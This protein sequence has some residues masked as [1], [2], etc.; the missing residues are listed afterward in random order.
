M[1]LERPPTLRQ[2]R[3]GLEEALEANERLAAEYAYAA[4]KCADAERRIV[5]EVN[6][7]SKAATE[8]ERERSREVSR[9]LREEYEKSS[10]AT[11][12]RVRRLRI[13]LRSA[14]DRKRRLKKERDDARR[15]LGSTEERVGRRYADEVDSLK[16]SLVEGEGKIRRMES[17]VMENDGIVRE[18]RERLMAEIM[19]LTKSFGDLRSELAN[20]AH[21][22]EDCIAT[23]E[24]EAAEKD[25]RIFALEEELTAANARICVLES[26]I[27]ELAS[28]LEDERAISANLTATVTDLRGELDS[29]RV[30]AAGYDDI[31]AILRREV[32]S[33]QITVAE[34]DYK[35]KSYELKE[36][37]LAELLG[38]ASESLARE[39]ERAMVVLEDKDTRIAVLDRELAEKFDEIYTVREA[40]KK[41]NEQLSNMTGMYNTERHRADA[42][43]EKIRKLNQLTA[44]VV[45]AKAIADDDADFLTSGES[46]RLTKFLKDVIAS[47]DQYKSLVDTYESKM[48]FMSQ[49]LILSEQNVSNKQD[50]IKSL[51]RELV[52]ATVKAQDMTAD[53][54]SNSSRAEVDDT[55]YTIWKAQANGMIVQLTNDLKEKEAS[56]MELQKRLEKRLNNEQQ[57]P[58]KELLNTRIESL[59][60]QIARLK[61]VLVET[62]V[63]AKKRIKHKNQSLK[64]MQ[65]AVTTLTAEMEDLRREKNQLTN[66]LSEAIQRREDDY[67]IH[68]RHLRQT[69]DRLS[70]E[71]IVNMKAIE[72][73]MNQT[74]QQLEVEIRFLKDNA[75]PTLADASNDHSKVQEMEESL[76]RSKE[77]EVSL[78][79][80]NMMMKQKLQEML[81]QQARERPPVISVVM[82]D[83]DQDVDNDR[84]KTVKRL[85]TYYTE[86]Q[87]P[88]VIQFVG[89]AWKKLFRR[90][91]L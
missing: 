26:Q 48:K 32:E 20:N 91:K 56:I 30:N 86:R 66:Q 90:K 19:F 12:E 52:E 38:K 58:Q 72:D 65:D 2:V 50:Q 61:L 5:D 74:I 13:A 1:L 46:D 37:E 27:K 29:A 59:E 44:G 18:E 45:G 63:K 71:H 88:G 24:R 23:Y 57:Q 70:K 17:L 60:D 28:E 16:R 41:T 89:N 36:R 4:R 15:K 51:R 77:K 68:K 81:E 34:S 78:I 85:P 49:R 22:Y 87:G 25:A 42:L 79:N 3:G 62:Q 35:A 55:Q 10:E 33:Y 82:D 40:A 84:S 9:R 83:E 8:D 73:E 43:D 80:Q 7:A 75:E 31:I 67:Q 47:N 76:R 53:K 64:E 54:T 14:N 21:M 39:K 11:S 6:M 69:E